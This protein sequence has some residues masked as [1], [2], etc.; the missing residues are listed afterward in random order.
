MQKYE[1][2]ENEIE[3]SKIHQTL[4]NASK[5]VDSYLKNKSSLMNE[6]SI[7]E[8]SDYKFQEYDSTLKQNIFALGYQI[9]RRNMLYTIQQKNKLISKIF[10]FESINFNE[11]SDP[12]NIRNILINTSNKNG[13]FEKIISSLIWMTYRTNFKPIKVS[14]NP[15]EEEKIF[16]SDDGWGCAIRLIKNRVGQMALAN[17]IAY[18]LKEKYMKEKLVSNLSQEI[19]L[20]ILKL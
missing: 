13:E 3:N 5:Q 16:T 20:E 11:N 18:Y 1:I 9:N 15:F 7:E 4:I 17:G 19:V 2:I 8:E 12:I 10:G 6:V 14:N